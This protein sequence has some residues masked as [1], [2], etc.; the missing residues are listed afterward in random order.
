MKPQ[1]V[2]E[3]A[4]ALIRIPSVNPDGETDGSETGEKACAEFVA[5]F[6]ESFGGEAALPEVLPGRPNVVVR[7]PSAAPRKSRILFAPHTD[8]VSV[9]GM[10]VA[11]FA[12]ELREGKIWGRG[13]SDTKGPMAAML[14]A[15]HESRELLA[16]LPHEIWFAGLMG[17]EA[18][19]HG[20]KAL[21][22]E[23]AFD[24]VI[25]GEPTGLRTVNC[26]KGQV[27][28][29]LAT[30]GKACHASQPER[31]ENAIYK[32]LDLAAC[33]RDE[34]APE[35]ERQTHPLL[36]HSTISLGTIRGG[37]KVNI[38]PDQCRAQVDIRL[39]PGFSADAAIRRLREVCPDVQI[40]ASLSAPL[41]T[42]ENHPLVQKLVEAGAPCTGAP[43][44]C[45][46]AAFAEKGVPAVAIGPGSIE[47]AHTADE[48]IAV[49]D[50][51]AGVDFFRRFLRSL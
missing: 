37:S 31:G 15:L 7:F 17:E 21:A 30:A 19:L 38:V 8:T 20:S 32:M 39:V 22:A 41:Q 16:E 24:F 34:I 49:S 18:G 14:W 43:W 36:G 9:A 40:D 29:T 46:A 12:A 35:L 50:L 33:V 48:W 23:T 4:Q 42:S 3:L 13:A 2:V 45:D 11:P 44:F 27:R 10:T 28:L 25:V 26:H 1:T 47:Q 5:A 6:C 51:E